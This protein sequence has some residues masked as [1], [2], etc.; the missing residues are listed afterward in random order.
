MFKSCLP[1]VFTNSSY[2]KLCTDE[3]N[4][5]EMT[6]KYLD[7]TIKTSFFVDV[8]TNFQVNDEKSS[9]TFDHINIGN[10]NIKYDY[11]SHFSINNNIFY[12]FLYGEINGKNEIIYCDKPMFIKIFFTSNVH[13]YM[14]MRSIFK[15]IK[16]YKLMKIHDHTAQTFTA[17][18]L[19]K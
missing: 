15:I 9:L 19:K 18:K 12:I 17:F 8:N 10:Y 4:E 6:N 7:F 13:S 2:S 16:K 5:C 11:I 1:C 3:P 14:Y